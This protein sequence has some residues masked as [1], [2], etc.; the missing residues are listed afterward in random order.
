MRIYPTPRGSITPH[1]YRRICCRDRK[2]R[3]EH[4]LVWETLH[5]PIPSGMEVHHVNGDKLDNRIANLV[6]VSR[7]DHKRIHEGCYRCGGRWFK[8]CRR[9]RWY[10][11]IDDEFYVYPGGKGVSTYCRRC[12]VDLAVQNKRKGTSKK[13]R[14]CPGGS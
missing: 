13:S 11:A 7:L 9:C 3:F 12:A 14:P 10:R 2:Q 4:V 5:G 1:G 6:L 8:R